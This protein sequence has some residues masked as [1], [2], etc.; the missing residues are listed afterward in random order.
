MLTIEERERLDRHSV[1]TQRAEY[2]DADLWA[3]LE[4]L[5]ER[6]NELV[7]L[8][9][10]SYAHAFSWHRDND[11]WRKRWEKLLNEYQANLGVID[12]LIWHL[13]KRGIDLTAWLDSYKVQQRK[14]SAKAQFV[15]W[16]MAN[17]GLQ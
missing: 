9:A 7:Q 17:G 16:H 6:E 3:R 1:E 10:V 5:K 15:G 4:E 13:T 12:C 8:L 2:A 14:L 11:L